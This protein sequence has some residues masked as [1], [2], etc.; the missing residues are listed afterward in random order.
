MRLTVLG[1]GDAF[2]GSGCNAAYLV[3][4]RAV[5]DCGAPVHVLAR[6]VAVAV[7]DI[8]LILLTHFHADHS[9][10]LPMFLGAS[11]FGRSPV[12]PGL[13]IAGPAGIREFSYRL[14]RDG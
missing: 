12:E 14:L 4:K 10:M 9:F 3:D 13:I 7:T 1:S 11:A 6:R 8:R 5:V 2:S